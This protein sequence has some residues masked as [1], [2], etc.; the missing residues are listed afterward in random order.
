[1]NVNKVLHKITYKG[2]DKT[3]NNSYI[4]PVNERRGAPLKE[5]LKKE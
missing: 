3:S 4:I 2:V 1:M 5:Q